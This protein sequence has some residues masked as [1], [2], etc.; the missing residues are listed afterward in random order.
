MQRNEDSTI[1]IAAPARNAAGRIVHRRRAL[2]RRI[3]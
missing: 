2:I 1:T 3:I